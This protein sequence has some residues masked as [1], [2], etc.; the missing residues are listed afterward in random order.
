[1]PKYSPVKHFSYITFL[2]T[3]SATIT[4]KSC[5]LHLNARWMSWMEI[6][7]LNHIFLRYSSPPFSCRNRNPPSNLWKT[8]LLPILCASDSVY[9]PANSLVFPLDPFRSTLHNRSICSAYLFFHF[10]RFS[11]NS[12]A[13]SL[14]KRSRT[15]T[16]CCV[17]SLE[18]GSDPPTGVSSC[19]IVDLASSCKD[20]LFSALWI[21]GC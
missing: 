15:T 19:L 11:E 16:K 6:N 18:L 14:V 7:N 8:S 1:M 10:R 20:E 21:N 17:E 3:R 12:S 9:S 5:E 4:P 13:V 2:T